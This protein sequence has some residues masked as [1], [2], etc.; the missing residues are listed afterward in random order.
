[1]FKKNAQFRSLKGR[2]TGS[3]LYFAGHNHGMEK[4]VIFRIKQLENNC[5]SNPLFVH[6]IIIVA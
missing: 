2:G 6:N 4:K 1:M 3:E 5:S